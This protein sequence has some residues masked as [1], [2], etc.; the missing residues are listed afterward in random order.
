[1]LTQ[2]EVERYKV[3][4]EKT[5][6]EIKK[7][8]T[9]I[10]EIEEAPIRGNI[11]NIDFYKGNVE[12]SIVEYIPGC[13]DEYECCV[14]PERFLYEEWEEEYKETVRLKRIAEQKEK[15]EKERLMKEKKEKA[16]R[17]KYEELKKKFESEE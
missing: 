17:E 3:L 7:I 10:S 4:R 1:M 2:Q 12:I 16:E 13:G 5:N 14:F 6:K 8:L 15:E 9:R 11:D